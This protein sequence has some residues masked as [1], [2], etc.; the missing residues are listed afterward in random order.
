MSSCLV[1]NC[2]LQS[3]PINPDQWE[4]ASLPVAEIILDDENPRLAPTSR[5]SVGAIRSDMIERQRLMDLVK[6]IV[7]YGGLFPQ[8]KII[9]LDTGPGNDRFVVLEGN[10]RVYA[11]QLLLKPGLAPTPEL[12]DAVPRID[13]KL[14]ERIENI[15]AV[16]VPTKPIARE[17]IAALHA[18]DSRLPWS[19]L[20]RMN[21]VSDGFRHDLTPIEMANTLQIDIDEIYQLSA[22]K[23][24]FE[25]YPLV[26]IPF[27]DSEYISNYYTNFEPFRK[28][29][30]SPA[31]KR[32]FGAELFTKSGHVNENIS[33]WKLIVKQMFYHTIINNHKEADPKFGIET[34]INEFLSVHYTQFRPSTTKED[35][36]PG[37][38]SLPQNP[39]N[40]VNHSEDI[41]AN[42]ASPL[43]GIDSDPNAT[44][45]KPLPL[46]KRPY[47]SQV[48]WRQVY[49]FDSLR[50][51][52]MDDERLY[53][54][55][56][57]LRHI[58]PDTFRIASFFLLRACLEWCLNY[59]LRKTGEWENFLSSTSSKPHSYSF[60]QIIDFCI[61][62]KNNIFHDENVRFCLEQARNKKY[63]KILG[64]SIHSD[65]ST[66]SESVLLEIADQIRPLIR[67]ITCDFEY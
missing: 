3:V 36:I 12:A 54:L 66:P 16:V 65:K 20:A 23:V 10:R 5:G 29:A 53:Q 18:Q 19:H 39:P 57:E 7:R 43:N 35:E 61:S 49:W 56:H 1:G 46:E 33:N 38:L 62:S 67:Y 45:T 50:C 21:Y 22:L 44:T 63:I 2:G 24:A 8:E 58:K 59:H 13:K 37:L 26:D 11:C 60:S 32:F 47:R 27:E 52:R 42:V 28:L 34:G 31:T 14:R 15:A 64:I 25:H 48:P 41:A 51:T 40:P 17:I 4:E 9:V 55:C 6:S 30:F